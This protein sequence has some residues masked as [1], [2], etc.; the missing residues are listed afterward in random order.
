M[1]VADRLLYLLS[2]HPTIRPIV[3]T[4]HIITALVE[5]YE[6]YGY[7]SSAYQYVASMMYPSPQF[8]EIQNVVIEDEG[9]EDD[10]LA[11][12]PG[13]VNVIDLCDNGIMVCTTDE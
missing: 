11:V 1:P 6:I 5:A 9:D 2:F 8:V 7:T 4:Y 13:A 3:T 10:V 12:G